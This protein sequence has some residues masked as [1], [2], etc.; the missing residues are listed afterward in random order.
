M[1]PRAARLDDLR[2][3]HVMRLLERARELESAGRN[4]VHMEIGEPDFATPEPVVA[5]GHQALQ[6][7]RVHYTPARGL[8]TLRQAVGRYYH[9][10]YGVDVDPNRILITPG[11]SGALQLALAAL[12]DPGRGVMLSDPGYPCNRNL[13]RLIEGTVQAV[14][15][16]AVEGYQLTPQLAAAHWR[17]DTAA[18][19]VAT[20]ANPSGTLLPRAALA[21][22]AELCRGRSTALIV[23]EIYQGLTY[24]AE[25]ITALALGEDIF[26]I[27]SFS[28]FFGMTGW[29]LG[30]LVV[31]P[32]YAADLDV[33]AQNL[34]L[35]AGTLSQRAALAAFA[36]ATRTILEQ[37]RETFRQRRDFLLPALRE[38]GFDIPVTPEGA[39]YLYANCRAL[40]GDSFELSQRLLEE[41]GVAVTPG[42]DFG[43]HR[44]G[45]HVR[46][47]YTTSLEMLEEGVARLRRFL[48]SQA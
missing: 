13:V 34:F 47:A 3:F 10:R 48:C 20:P 41:A 31:P 25:D 44:A 46:F 2:P 45:E 26:V 32:D 33:L 40:A 39:F 1:P 42:I 37:R 23:D 36:P 9:E 19:L 14:P 17:A 15:V 28:K 43:D 27:N 35:A 22:L 4:I 18:V 29:R 38:L 5:A 21:E 7:G 8:A 24:G 30:W 12:V 6:G 16:G 11:A